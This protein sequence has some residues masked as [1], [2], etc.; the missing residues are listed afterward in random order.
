MAKDADTLSPAL[1]DDVERSARDLLKA[2]SDKEL[3]LCTAESCTGGLLASLL[4]DVSGH[5]HVFE[6]GFVT[7]SD[8]AKCDLLGLVQKRIDACGAV[9]REVAIAMAEGALERS[10]ADIA[11]SLT[12]FAGP[13]GDDD[14]EG[15]VHIAVARKGG[16]TTHREEHFG[17]NGR[18]PIRIASI[19]SALAM[20]RDA[21]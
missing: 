9:S 20:M 12:G 11:A 7:Y 17:P 2:A 3:S 10:G 8:A 4:T 13:A 1:P 19:R 15:L 18:G 21:V 14:E 5:S 6:R 16:E